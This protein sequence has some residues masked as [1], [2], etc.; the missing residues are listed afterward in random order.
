L[1]LAIPENA[2]E[3]SISFLP[4]LNGV[5]QSESARSNLM[6][7]SARGV[8]AIRQGP[9]KLIIDCDNSG[10]IKFGADGHEG[11]GPQPHMES[12][13]YHLVDDPFEVYNR[14]EDHA[15]IA[16]DLRRSAEAQQQ[17]ARSAPLPN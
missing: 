15:E 10:G 6:H 1:D 3:D 7:H 13:L 16:A 9:W 17:S 4:A 12:Q 2:A 5:E 14:I 8:F 11:T